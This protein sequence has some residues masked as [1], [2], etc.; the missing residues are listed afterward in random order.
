MLG[1]ARDA[2]AD[3]PQRPRPVA[4]R[5]VEERAR[6]LA[7]PRARRR[8]RPAARSSAC[9]SRSRDSG[10]SSSPCARSGRARAG[11]RRAA[12]PS[13]VSSSCSRSGSPTSR[14]K[15]SSFEIEMR[16]VE[17]SS[18]RGS[19]PRARSRTMR[20]TLPGSSARSSSSPSAASAPIVSIAGGD[21]AAPRRAGR[22]PAAGGSRAARGTPP[23][24]PG[25]TIVSP[26]GL[27]RSEAIFATTFE[28]ASAERAREPRARA[29]HGLHRLGERAGVVERRRDLAE[30]EVALVDPG[31]LDRRHDLAHERPHLLRV[32]AVERR[33]A[34]RT[35]VTRRA[36][37]Q[38]LG[39]RH[40]REDAEPP[41][42]VVR[43]RDH[44]AAVRVAADD[45]RPPAQLGALELLDGGEEG[46]QVEVRDDH[47]RTR[48]SGRPEADAYG[49]RV[50]GVK[51]ARWPSESMISQ[52]AV[53]QRGARSASSPPATSSK[54]ALGRAQA[55]GSRRAA[56][57]ERGR[58][59]RPRSNAL[60]KRVERARAEEGDAGQEDDRVA[61][62]EEEAGGRGEAAHDRA[63]A[64]PTV[65]ARPARAPSGCRERCTP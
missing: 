1:E 55:Q 13:G 34:A 27:R 7:D 57:E 47:G 59:R 42:R 20:P 37:P 36:A 43:G 26:P 16:S 5:A 35:N 24:G 9:G 3:E 11:A 58:A 49:C 17:T 10:A 18:R 54:S 53:A 46:V 64:A 41:R 38:R 12:R 19:M 52:L 44:A 8:C 60:E 23:R 63:E 50:E 14:G 33:A 62:G 56:R 61:A 4:Q 39:A 31:L 65:L 22:S 2:D 6:E 30:V 29:D 51:E 48:L 15:V 28:L 32:L 25:R 40:R 45:E 21:A